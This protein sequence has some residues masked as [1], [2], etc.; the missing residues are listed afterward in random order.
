VKN[1]NGAKKTMPSYNKVILIGRLTRNPVIR[2][3]ARG[4]TYC[5][6]SIALNRKYRA[7]DGSE[8]D[9]V[10]YVEISVNGVK[11]D[12]CARNLVKGQQ[13]YVEGFFRLET[14][15]PKKG[16]ES[17]TSLR[18]YADQILFLDKSGAMSDVRPPASSAPIGAK[19]F[20]QRQPMPPPPMPPEYPDF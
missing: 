17:R 8:R 15:T 14:W 6:F 4:T 13:V 16:G 11:A 5:D 9:E 2:S 10:T 3:T 18:V 7:Q 1:F 20:A 12:A 19:D